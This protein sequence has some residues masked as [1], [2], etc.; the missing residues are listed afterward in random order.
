MEP[1]WTVLR[2]PY[3]W[4]DVVRSATEGRGTILSQHVLLAHAEVCDLYVSL[5]I[6][7]HVVQLKVSEN[8]KKVWKVYLKKLLLINL[9]IPKPV[10]N[11]PELSNTLKCL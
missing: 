8:K 9:F 1:R 5:V 7:H 4:S 11:S 10:T 6:Q 2:G 3:L